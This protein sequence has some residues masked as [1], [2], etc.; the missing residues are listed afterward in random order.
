VVLEEQEVVVLDR[1]ER[2]LVHRVHKIP[3]AAVVVVDQDLVLETALAAL[4]VQV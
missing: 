4:A 3:V 2:Q 1:L